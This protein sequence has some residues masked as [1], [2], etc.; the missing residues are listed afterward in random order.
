M[1]IKKRGNARIQW[2]KKYIPCREIVLLNY[3][4]YGTHKGNCDPE[5]AEMGRG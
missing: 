4:K 3:I 5:K 2:Q 1:K